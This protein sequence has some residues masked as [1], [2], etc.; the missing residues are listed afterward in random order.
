MLECARIDSL[1]SITVRR[2]PLL[3]AAA[4]HILRLAA[5][6][7][8]INLYRAVLHWNDARILQHEAETL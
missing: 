7:A 4:V 8:L 5:V 2:N 1:V 6:E 3:R